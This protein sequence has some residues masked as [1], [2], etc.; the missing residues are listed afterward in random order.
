MAKVK[1]A[2][3]FKGHQSCTIHAP[4]GPVVCTEQKT[5]SVSG[6]LMTGLKLDTDMIPLWCQYYLDDCSASKPRL[7][8]VRACACQGFGDVECGKTWAREESGRKGWGVEE[9]VLITT[10]RCEDSDDGIETLQMLFRESGLRKGTNS[11][12]LE[13]RQTGWLLF[14]CSGALVDKSNTFSSDSNQTP[15]ISANLLFALL[16]L[17]QASTIFKENPSSQQHPRRLLQS[18]YS[19]N[20]QSCW[21]GRKWHKYLSFNK[22]KNKNKRNT[23]RKWN[24]RS[25]WQSWCWASNARWVIINTKEKILDSIPHNCHK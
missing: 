21:G 5:H 7:R 4:L 2:A 10:Q 3:L 25:W 17:R 6:S 12:S 8:N 11:S 13:L 14:Q 18:L 15:I 9:D 24:K 22:R 20:K 19:W 16:S 23:G 1:P